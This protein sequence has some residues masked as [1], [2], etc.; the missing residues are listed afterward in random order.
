MRGSS[1]ILLVDCG[2]YGRAQ[3]W[4]CPGTSP[5]GLPHRQPW[6]DW[7]VDLDIRAFFDSD[8]GRVGG[9][10]TRRG[11]VRAHSRGFP[12]V[13]R[14][15]PQLRDG[16]NA[17]AARRV[18]SPSLACYRASL[19]LPGP[20]SRPQRRQAHGSTG[21]SSSRATSSSASSIGC[22]WIRRPG[23]AGA[24][25]EPV[26]RDARHSLVW[27][28]GWKAVALHSG[29]PSGWSHFAQDRSALSHVQEHR[30][31]CHDLADENPEL[32]KEL[33]ALWH[34]EAGQYYGLPLQDRTAIDVLT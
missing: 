2:A 27:R 11:G 20:D 19:Q 32:L 17:L 31:E 28:D 24:G 10:R 34:Y 25:T 26:L 21:G 16:V 23:A 7:F 5:G 33:I 14:R 13:S 6:K 3:R 30:S 18:A 8:W 9:R 29:A 1:S 12:V 22:A 4:Q 15:L